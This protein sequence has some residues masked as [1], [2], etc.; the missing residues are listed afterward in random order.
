M[1]QQIPDDTIRVGLDLDA[2][3]I[4]P[5]ESKATYAEIKSYVLDTMG[6]KV[7]Y[8]YIAQVKRKY[9][10]LERA[11]YNMPKSENVRQPKCP[12]EKELAIRAAM[13]HFGM[14]WFVKS[15]GMKKKQ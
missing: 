10:I 9:G 14:I 12:L 11:C 8:L 6:V 1:S 5:T 4:T 3:D 13:E 2:F 15:Q 7:S